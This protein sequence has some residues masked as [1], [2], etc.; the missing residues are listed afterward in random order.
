MPLNCQ[1][2]CAGKVASGVDWMPASSAEGDAASQLVRARTTHWRWPGR[3]T[4]QW[5][6]S[7]LPLDRCLA[8]VALG[9]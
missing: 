5:L 8:Y 2:A 9:A 1:R 7:P 3:E 6:L 4:I